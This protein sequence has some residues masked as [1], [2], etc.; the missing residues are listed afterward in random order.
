MIWLANVHRVLLFGGQSVPASYNETWMYNVGSKTWTQKCLSACTPPP[1]WAGGTTALPAIAYVPSRGTAV[2]H[3]TSPALADWEYNPNTDAWSQLTSI[4]AGSHAAN[5]DAYM[6]YDVASGKLVT[7]ST[8][9]SGNGGPPEIWTGTFGSGGSTDSTAPT[10]PSGI[11]SV[12]ST[13]SVSLSWTAS[14]DPDDAVSY[15]TIYR[16][17][18][19]V[20]SPSAASFT[21]NGLTASTNYNYTI[22]ATDTHGNTSAQSTVKSVTTTAGAG[23][24]TPPSVPTNLSATAITSSQINLSWT[25]STDNVAVTGYKIYRGGSQ[26]ST[27]VTNSYSD[28]GLSASTAYTYTVSAYDA[29]SNNSAQSSSASATTGAA[30]GGSWS[31]TGA[32]SGQFRSLETWP[33]GNIKWIKVCGIVSS[34]SAGG[35]TTVTLT[36]PNGLSVP[37]TIQEALYSAGPTGV[38]R[39]N[40]PFCT[41]TPVPDSF[42]ISPSTVGGASSN[43]ATD[44]G[45]TITVDTGTAQFSIKKANFNGI[46]QAVINGTTVVQPSTSA[47][48]G[49]IV[50]AAKPNCGLPGKCYLL[51]Q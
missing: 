3:E 7:W 43:L 24:T 10:V 16:S 5:I 21:D 37:L 14:T 29:A 18:T 9:G 49:L 48:R 13:T 32:S 34:L 42:G 41:G 44:N 31:L 47:S 25:A 38:A 33:S 20:G 50:M 26:I 40:E 28:S 39:T 22:S 12:A 1:I 35:T 4:G 30:T 2:F 19:A 46:D 6:T 17:G 36:G 51:S 27:S 11:N 15:Y 23:D 8:N 45:A